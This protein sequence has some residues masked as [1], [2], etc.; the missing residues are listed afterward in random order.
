MRS[1]IDL[2]DSNYFLNFLWFIFFYSFIAERITFNY[3][4]KVYA[5]KDIKLRNINWQGA[6][7]LRYIT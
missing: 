4:I 5:V 1:A 3:S 2:N 6:Y 7:D